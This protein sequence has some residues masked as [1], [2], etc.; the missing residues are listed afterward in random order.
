MDGVLQMLCAHSVIHFPYPLLPHSE[1]FPSVIGRRQGYTMDKSPVPQAHLAKANIIHTHTHA[2]WQ[3]RVPDWLLR[4]VFWSVGGS[5]R[6]RREP[7]QVPRSGNQTHNP[8]QS[9]RH[10][11]IHAAGGR[12]CNSQYF[13]TRSSNDIVPVNLLKF[14][15]VRQKKIC[16]VSSL[17]EAVTWGR[18]V[19]LHYPEAH[20]D[21]Q[22]L[23]HARAQMYFDRGVSDVLGGWTWAASRCR[24]CTPLLVLTKSSLIDSILLTSVHTVLFSCSSCFCF[25]GVIVSS[26]ACLL[27]AAQWLLNLAKLKSQSKVELICFFFI[28]SVL[29]F[30]CVTL[31]CVNASW[32][33]C[34]F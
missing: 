27:A 2:T 14:V 25:P 26:V 17:F 8:W 16:H 24:P 3:F 10:C 21:D 23:M 34:Q 33:N 30:K 4:H 22:N 15:F 18:K 20:S 31:R 29:L 7:T 19:L 1:P 32:H 5:R 28:H 12:G 13:M 9:L 11:I 6:T